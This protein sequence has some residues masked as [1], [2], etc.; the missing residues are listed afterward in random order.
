MIG[1]VI[2]ALITCAS[3]TLGC[4]TL[5][6]FMFIHKKSWEQEKRDMDLRYAEIEAKYN[7]KN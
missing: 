1:S 3:F 5:T 7:G 4:G 2:P 6:L